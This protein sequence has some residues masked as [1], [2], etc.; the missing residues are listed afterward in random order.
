M[1]QILRFPHYR[2]KPGMDLQA[3]NAAQ[4]EVVSAVRRQLETGVADATLQRK[5]VLFEKYARKIPGFGH[6]MKTWENM[7]ARPSQEAL[8][9]WTGAWR[10][11][12]R[13]AVNPHRFA[14]PVLGFWNH[15]A[16]MTTGLNN[17]FLVRLD[18]MLAPQRKSLS[19]QA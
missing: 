10:D 8:D 16:R 6:W 14:L 18:K 12:L 9:L 15:V 3:I 7:L 11:V 19:M 1:V 17:V 2:A 4:R 13:D 5:V